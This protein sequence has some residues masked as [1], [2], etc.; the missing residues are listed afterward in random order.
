[1]TAAKALNI[2]ELHQLARRRLPRILFD[3]IESGTEGETA[4]A[5]N[6]ASFGR[7]RLMP[8]HLVDVARRDAGL[9]LFGRRY[10]QS[11]G[12]G[13]T[14]FAGLFRPGAD[15]MLARAAV[16]ADI[17]FVLSGASIASPE[18]IAAQATGRL[19][20][21]LYAAKDP[22]ISADLMRRVAAAGVEVLVLTVDNPVPAKRERD[23]RNGFS[24]PLR[25]KPSILLEALTHPGWII[26]YLRD[27]G[28]PGMGSWAA[29]APPGSGPAEIGQFFR[30]HSPSIQTWD[31]LKR[32][33]EQWRGK[34]VLKG[35]QHPE[36]ARMAL[37]AGVDGL[38]VSNHGGKAY[39]M[40]PIPLFSLAAVKAAVGAQIPVMFDGG[41]RRGSDILIA[42]A[43]GADFVFTGRAT[44]YGVVA[45]G[46]AG[47]ARAVEILRDEVD[48][49]LAMIGCPKIADLDE[50]WLQPTAQ[51]LHERPA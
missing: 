1:M 30:S 24:L 5:A 40:L 32:F 27:G 10:A 46:E 39:D 34:L 4:L 28:L 43:L 41:V 25:L 3:C 14:G 38:I 22:A 9:S 19:W 45:G 51:S 7:Y 37:A 35:I 36:D 6:E 21:H 26:G 47:A 17:P 48:R 31:D 29:Y 23:I 20:Y 42:R 11:F 18:A 49:G 44:L 50:R 33:R 8:R 2:A 15:A 12:I 13:P 16:A